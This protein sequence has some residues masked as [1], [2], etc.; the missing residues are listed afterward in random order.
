MEV[1]VRLTNLSL[2]TDDIESSLAALL[3]ANY[4]E[5]HCDE[6]MYVSSVNL[7]VTGESEPEHLCITARNWNRR[8]QAHLNQTITRWNAE[9]QTLDTQTTYELT[10]AALAANDEIHPYGLFALFNMPTES[11]AEDDADY[12]FRTILSD[13]A[14]QDIMAHPE[15]YV[16]C[17]MSIR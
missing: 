9:N 15:Q 17:D 3:K 2:N 6:D 4:Q 11:L 14:E 13:L 12:R 7:T 16:I 8:L 1:L 10:K 5:N